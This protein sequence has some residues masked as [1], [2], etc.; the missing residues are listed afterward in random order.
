MSDVKQKRVTRIEFLKEL[1]TTDPLMA[2]DKALRLLKIRF[3][4]TKAKSKSI[5]TWKKMLRDGGLEIPKQ[6]VGA[7]PQQCK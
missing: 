7:K 4:A 1:Y 6:R 2:N 5:T 3:P